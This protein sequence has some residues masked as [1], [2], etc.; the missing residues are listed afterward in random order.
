[1]E[2][3]RG[4]IRIKLRLSEVTS[5]GSYVGVLQASMDLHSHFATAANCDQ[6]GQPAGRSAVTDG[7]SLAVQNSRNCGFEFASF[8]CKRLLASH[9]DT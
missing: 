5:Q 3:L 7:R 1:M 4:V 9:S 2:S 8:N 6:D